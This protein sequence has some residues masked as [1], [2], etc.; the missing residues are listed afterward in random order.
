MP[1]PPVPLLIP[2]SS[3]SLG[4][5]V[6]DGGARFGAALLQSHQI[7]TLAQLY[8]PGYGG[9]VG[10]TSPDGR[11]VQRILLGNVQVISGSVTVDRTA[12]FRRS[13][14]GLQIVVP[15]PDLGGNSVLVPGVGSGSFI[16]NWRQYIPVSSEDNFAPHGTELVLWR[17]IAY[18][19][20]YMVDGVPVVEL[21]P[22]GIFNISCTDVTSVGEGLM[23]TLDGYDR[24]RRISRATLTK[25]QLYLAN[26]T[27]YDVI[28][29][30]LTMQCGIGTS[31]GGWW[32]PG[33]FPAPVPPDP[34]A[35]GSINSITGMLEYGLPPLYYQV[36]DDPWAEACSLA[37][38]TGSE[39][40][41]DP[42]GDTCLQ[43]IPNVDTYGLPPV[44]PVASYVSAEDP[45][46]DPDSYSPG[47][48]SV[49]P[50]WDD[51]YVVNTW[52]VQGGGSTATRYTGIARDVNPNSP[53]NVY[54]YGEVSAQIQSSLLSNPTMA[55]AMARGLL[56]MHT[57]IVTSVQFGL[58]PDPRLQ[59]GNAIQIYYPR[60]GITSVHVI[61]SLSIPL[62]AGTAMTGTTREMATL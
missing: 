55:N 45:P 47:L 40:F 29:T 12:Q 58:I 31:L 48:L 53:T 42:Y 2:C 34:N 61:E 60:A 13:F 7:A 33:T 23:L 59:P 3:L 22:L 5:P 36:N 44:T 24:S 16:D 21:V 27:V 37:T 30:M 38:V 57:G 54:K 28:Y 52:L 32:D 26:A 19:E 10:A 20:D 39:I 4:T 51:Q 17:G 49:D 62:D 15:Y 9:I 1:A 8:V 11:T 14:S 18:G 35:G 25:A 50:K 46:N 6:A 43:Q 41:I 56:M